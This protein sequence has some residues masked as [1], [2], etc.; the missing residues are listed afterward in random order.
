LE[1][2]GRRLLADLPT[3]VPRDHAVLPRLARRSLGLGFFSKA[4]ERHL[5]VWQ[6]ELVHVH[7]GPDALALIPVVRRLKLPLAVTF[8]GFDVTIDTPVN[9]YHRRR[10]EV[11]AAAQTVFAVSDF[12]RERLIERDCTGDKIV[13]HFIGFDNETFR[14]RIETERDIPVLFVGRLVEKKGW[15]LLLQAMAEVQAQHPDVH[16]HMVGDGPD[17]QAAESLAE[18]LRVKVTWH[19][20]QRP[21][22]V[23]SFMGRAQV[24]SPP[25]IVAPNGDTEGWGLVNLEAQASGAPRSLSRAVGC[26]KGS[27]TA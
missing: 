23:A 27:M 10:H 8:H 20:L 22:Q 17:R 26:P 25:S 19:G 21:D 5:A 1:T 14:A 12:I 15:R 3:S 4:W 13:T 18:E 24:F 2:E 6:P 16:L 11:F 9:S 7:F